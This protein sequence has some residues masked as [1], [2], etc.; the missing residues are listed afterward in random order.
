MSSE[1]GTCN[2]GENLH[3]F[4]ATFDESAYRTATGEIVVILVLFSHRTVK[5]DE[6]QFFICCLRHHI[7]PV[8]TKDSRLV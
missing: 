7:S 5:E 8:I 1:E 4:N 6:R 3:N 2:G